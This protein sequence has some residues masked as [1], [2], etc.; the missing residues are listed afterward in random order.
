MSQEAI[1]NGQVGSGEDGS[2]DGDEKLNWREV[3]ERELPLLVKRHIT[4]P[5]LPQ[6][7][8]YVP[9]ASHQR[10]NKTTLDK[11]TL[12]KDLHIILYS[13]TFLIK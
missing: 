12:F 3:E 5:V 4:K 1:S 6:A 13:S 11:T 8:I 2:E 9:M 7:M 10:Y